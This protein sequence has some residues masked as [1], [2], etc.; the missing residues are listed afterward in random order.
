MK[1]FVISDLH[2]FATEVKAVLRRAGFNKKNKDHTLIVCGDVFD[3]GDESLEL[4]KYLKSIPKKRCILVKGN[5][6]TLYFELL[7]KD[8]P[9]Y[10]DATNGTL[11]TFFHISE[12]PYTNYF[13]E[14]EWLNIRDC[15]ANHEVTKWLKSD[16]WVDYFELDR[17]IFV[18]SFIPA[19]W[20]WRKNASAADWENARWGNPWKQYKAGLFDLEKEDGK[21]LVV[22]HWHVWDFHQNLGE[23][24]NSTS[25]DIYYSNHLIALD[26]GVI[27]NGWELTSHPN[28]LVIDDSDFSVCTDQNGSKLTNMEVLNNDR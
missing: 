15:V 18:H 28:V 27:S 1:Y 20:A 21:T 13:L 8:W 5:H 22:G 14:N 25:R 6:E 17:F 2:S 11:K 10:Y 16:Q 23:D 7:K 3:R 26:G 19:T 4:Y 24:R 12:K 9:H